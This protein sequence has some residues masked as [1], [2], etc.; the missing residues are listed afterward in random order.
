MNIGFDA[1]RYFHNPTGLGNYSRTLVN[2]LAHLYPQHQYFLFNPKE[3]V[4]F[5]VPANLPLTQILPSGLLHKTFSSYWRS[6]GMLQD[7]RKQKIDLFHGL[8]H[9]LPVGSKEAGVKS[10]VTVHDL[11]FERYPQ[12]YGTYEVLVHRRKIQ[13]ACRQADAVIAIS[14]QTKNDLLHFYGVPEEKIRVCYQSCD[15][16]F[17]ETAT[18]ETI[19]GLRLAYNLPQQFF[20]YV[21]SIIERKNLLRIGKAMNEAGPHLRLPLVVVGAG[22][23]YAQQV[24]T[25][26]RESGLENRVLFTS[27][28]EPHDPHFQLKSTRNLAA[29]YQMATG[30]IYPSLFEGF[31]IPVLEALWSGVPVITSNTSCLPETAGDAALLVDPTD[32]GAMAAALV[33]L[34]NDEALRKQLIAKGKM[35]AQKFTLRKCTAEVMAVY[36]QIVQHGSL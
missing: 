22:K 14:Q 16:I 35:Q 23:K 31:G 9:E 33:Q 1:K 24:S 15:P 21:G 20:L 17:A 2:G 26:L 29:L 25:F 7:V 36:Q 6:K 5:G 18:V 12:Q 11:I 4:K 10:V 3:P 30:F 8:S 13:H 28:T 27:A 32:V 19:E 34:Q